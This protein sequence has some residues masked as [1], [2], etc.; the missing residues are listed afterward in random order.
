MYPRRI[1]DI[2]QY[3]AVVLNGENAQ[4]QE[5]GQ[6]NRRKNAYIYYLTIAIFELYV[7]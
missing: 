5:F 6:K 7:I 3:R 4:R 2:S 1:A